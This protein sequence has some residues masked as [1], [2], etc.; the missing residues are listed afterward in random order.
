MNLLDALKQMTV[1]V[2]DTGDI[3][4]IARYTPR[5][6]MTVDQI[7][8]KLGGAGTAD[9]MRAAYAA[10]YREVSNLIRS[11]GE[12]SIWRRVVDG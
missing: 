1:V 10:A 7:D 12:G 5:A 3:E 4:S 6:R 11:E 2:S 8:R 9:E